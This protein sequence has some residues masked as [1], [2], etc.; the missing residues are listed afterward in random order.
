MT[1]LNNLTEKL[2]SYGTLQYES[3]QFATF[4]RKLTG[5]P[6][7]LTGY[8]ISQLQI[9]NPDV[10]ATSGES[11]HPVLVYTGNSDEHV[12]GMVFDITPFELQLSDK[13]E[14]AD[15]KRVSA[16]LKS[17]LTVWIYVGNEFIR[18]STPA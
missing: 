8:R 15:Y 3:V 5:N 6:D 1:L 13:Y 7:T 16:Q 11:V 14:I 12:D 4:G 9:T 2:F 18:S 17:G 10:I